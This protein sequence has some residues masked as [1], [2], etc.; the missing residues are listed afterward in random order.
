MKTKQL[1]AVAFL[2]FSSLGFGQ[3]YTIK[4]KM[5]Q[6]FEHPYGMSIS[7]AIA[8]D[9]FVYKEASNTDAKY[10]FDLNTGKF[11]ANLGGGR[12]RKG[13]IVRQFDATDYF[14]VEVDVDGVSFIGKL[15]LDND[16][17]PIFTVEWVEGVLV[18][19]FFTGEMKLRASLN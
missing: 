19:G 11:E 17:Q 13:T 16:D 14:V 8:N 7:G 9:L 4:V 10:V 18:K 12:T 15:Y 3:V 5:I 2:F 6:R 1:I